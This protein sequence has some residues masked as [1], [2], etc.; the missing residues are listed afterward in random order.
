MS[1]RLPQI[2]KPWSRVVL[3]VCAILAVACSV[4]PNDIHFTVSEGYRGPIAVIA[5]PEFPEPEGYR[6]LAGGYVL[7]VPDTGVVC[8]PS[9][10]IFHGYVHTAEYADGSTIY[11]HGSLAPD[12]GSIRLSGFGSWGGKT[13]HHGVTWFGVGTESEV[14]ALER[15]FFSSTIQNRMPQ[16]ITINPF[17]EFERFR[18]YCR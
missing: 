11:R 2:R 16:G 1:D 8:I 17:A 7:I 10:T 15:A 14:D 3:S 9:Y 5:S 6:S 18:Q 12:S 4:D 13:N